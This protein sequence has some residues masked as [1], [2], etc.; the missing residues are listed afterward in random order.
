[1]VFPLSAS[2]ASIQAKIPRPPV[3][4]PHHAWP[5]LQPLQ[6]L[7]LVVLSFSEYHCCYETAR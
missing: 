6:P 4:F 7:L 2:H 1:M 5:L 3:F